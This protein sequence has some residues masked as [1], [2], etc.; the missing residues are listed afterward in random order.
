MVEDSRAGRPVFKTANAAHT[1]FGSRT[2]LGGSQWVA[3]KG[4]EPQQQGQALRQAAYGALA[5][6][7]AWNLASSAVSASR[8]VNADSTAFTA[9]QMVAKALKPT[10]SL[11]DLSSRRDRD[12]GAQPMG[13]VLS[14]VLERRIV[15][16]QRGIIRARKEVKELEQAEMHS[17][18]KELLQFR[19]GEVLAHLR[20]LEQ[21]LEM[22]LIEKQRRQSQEEIALALRER[23]SSLPVFSASAPA[24]VLT[25][26]LQS[27]TVPDFVEKMPGLLQKGRSYRAQWSY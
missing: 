10:K 9:T 25:T 4:Q 18:G 26:P 1:F 3:A 27:P 22:H 21:E 17:L 13:L 23:S 12:F 16:L 8:R 14:H 6:K 5:T 24:D 2:M 20:E 11:Y 19:R 15:T 7:Q